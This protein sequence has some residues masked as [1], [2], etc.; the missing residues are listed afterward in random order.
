MND[1]LNRRKFLG[2][3]AGAIATSG[4]VLELPGE[5]DHAFSLGRTA[6]ALHD[7]I[8]RYSDQNAPMGGGP[9]WPTLE[10]SSLIWAMENLR[11]CSVDRIQEL[12]KPF[13]EGGAS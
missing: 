4:A 2:G 5:A 8:G 11:D 10:Q 9:S 7:A 12:L 1:T 13:F 6:S 3:T